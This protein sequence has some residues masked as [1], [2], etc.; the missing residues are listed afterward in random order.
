MPAVGSS[1]R[2]ST[3]SPAPAL[4]A[5]DDVE[6]PVHPVAEVDVDAPRGPEH[7]RVAARRAGERM[8]GGVVARVGLALDDAAADAVHEQFAADQV[9]RH[10]EAR[11]RA[12]RA[13]S[14]TPA[15]PARA[16]ARGGYRRSRAALQTTRPKPSDGSDRRAA[17]HA[18]ARDD[19]RLSGERVDDD[20]LVGEP[21]RPS[22]PAG[23][24]RRSGRTTRPTGCRRALRAREPRRRVRTAPQAAASRAGG[25]RSAPRRRRMATTATRPPSSAASDVSLTPA[26]SRG[27][28]A[29]RARRRVARRAR[30]ARSRCARARP[31]RAPGARPRAPCRPAAHRRA[32]AAAAGGRGGARAA[33]RAWTR[34]PRALRARYAGGLPEVCA[35]WATRRLGRRSSEADAMSS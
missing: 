20:D 29:R 8:R 9:A 32:W 31:S 2:I 4:A 16:S 1:A 30:P 22:R 35:S 23:G 27:R 17:A 13:M 3:A 11:A 14:V 15:S 18:R 24:T 26:A 7:A 34:W 5:A 6:H 25:S 21:P 33:R 10:R 19:A 12:P 28:A